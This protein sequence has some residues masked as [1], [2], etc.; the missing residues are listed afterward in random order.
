[1]AW[2]APAPRIR[3]RWSFPAIASCARTG[4]WRA[5][6]GEFRASKRCSTAKKD[7]AGRRSAAWLDLG[8]VFRPI[9]FEAGLFDLQILLDV[10][11]AENEVIGGTCFEKLLLQGQPGGLVDPHFNLA[12]LRAHLFG[13]GR[14]F[15][16]QRSLAVEFMLARKRHG[17]AFLQIFAA[18]AETQAD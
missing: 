8:G 2:P 17:E 4:I 13:L 14:Q 12:D 7:P 10:A 3:S 6:A 15:E 18:R 16:Q 1:G 11:V 5:I 9:R